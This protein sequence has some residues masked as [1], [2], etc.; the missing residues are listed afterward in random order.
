MPPEGLV[1]LPHQRAQQKHDQFFY[2]HKQSFCGK[3]IGTNKNLVDVL[4]KSPS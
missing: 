1:C 2:S 3:N 4:D